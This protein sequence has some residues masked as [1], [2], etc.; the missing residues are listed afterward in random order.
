MSKLRLSIICV[1]VIIT[2]IHLKYNENNHL[3]LTDYS[4]FPDTF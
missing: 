2:C 4:L 1:Q 3:I